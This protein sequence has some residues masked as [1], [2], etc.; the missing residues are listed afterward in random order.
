MLPVT[1][2]LQFGLRQGSVLS[3]VLFA[4]YIV[5]QQGIAV[6]SYTDDIMLIAPS[7]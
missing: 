3:P 5:V 4:I 6:I 7:V 1:F 2:E